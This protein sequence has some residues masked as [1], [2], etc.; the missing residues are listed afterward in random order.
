MAERDYSEPPMTAGDAM[1]PHPTCC[2]P[3]TPLQRV[4]Q[5]MVLQDCGEIP[6]VD[7]Q[8]ARVPVGVITDRD[9]VCRILARGKNPLE[10][11]AA[12]CMTEPVVTVDEA[13]PLKQA[14][15]V[16]ES[17]QIRRVPVVNTRG[18]C[19]GIVSQADI[20]WTGG[21]D[22]VADLVREVSRDTNEPSR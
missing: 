22:D 16:M 13:T 5:V 18:Q 21:K 4:A 1:T 7:D 2:T 17:H 15:A 3:D 19:V 6:V 20:A 12:D 14:V 10:H 9:I 11:T 8:A